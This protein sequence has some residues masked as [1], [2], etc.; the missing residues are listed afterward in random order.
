[1]PPACHSPDWETRAMEYVLIAIAIV[2]VALIAG[3]SLLVGRGRRTTRLDE[4]A[5]GGPTLTPP[6]PPETSG[7]TASG[8]GVPPQVADQEQPDSVSA[9]PAPEIEL[10]PAE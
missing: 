4:D 9:E 2:V 8:L 3:V 1:M 5:A 6:R 7:A 10:P